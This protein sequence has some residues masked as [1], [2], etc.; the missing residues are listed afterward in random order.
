SMRQSKLVII[1]TLS[2]TGPAT[3]ITAHSIFFRPASRLRY[4]SIA[5][6]MLGKS[7]HGYFTGVVISVS[8]RLTSAKRQFVPPTSPTK[9]KLGVSLCTRAPFKLAIGDSQTNLSRLRGGR[10]RGRPHARSQM[11][12]ADRKAKPT[13]GRHLERR[14][15]LAHINAARREAGQ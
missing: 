1:T 12:G 14:R 7:A 5:A 3:A 11:H 15:H 10:T 13:G 4:C 8:P 9:P 6:M 2:I